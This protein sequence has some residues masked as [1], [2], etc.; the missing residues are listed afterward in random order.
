MDPEQNAQ[1]FLLFASMKDLVR[2]EPMWGGGGEEE[3]TL[4]SDNTG[5]LARTIF[6]GIKL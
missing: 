3:D 2:Y 6:W 1:G 4:I 5:M